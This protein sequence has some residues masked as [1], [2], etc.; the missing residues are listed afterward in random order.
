MNIMTLRGVTFA[1]LAAGS[2]NGDKSGVGD[3][4][5]AKSVNSAV[6]AGLFLYVD[7]RSDS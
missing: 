6:A 1:A 7:D 3:K 4:L 5:L 2:G